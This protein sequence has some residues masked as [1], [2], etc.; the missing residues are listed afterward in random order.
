MWF[1]FLFR[2]S[3]FARTRFSSREAMIRGL[4]ILRAGTARF[5]V[6]KDESVG[7][8]SQERLTAL[9]ERRVSF[10]IIKKNRT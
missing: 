5:S 6:F 8:T 4:G 3:I 1:A 7:V 2:K 9:L 10:Q